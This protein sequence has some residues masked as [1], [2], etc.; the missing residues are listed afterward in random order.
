MYRLDLLISQTKVARPQSLICL[1][2]PPV[3]ITSATQPHQLHAATLAATQAAP[4][5]IVTAAALAT[6]AVASSTLASST[7]AASQACGAPLGDMCSP[8]SC[9]ALFGFAL[10]EPFMCVLVVIRASS[11]GDFGLFRVSS[12]GAT[13][14]RSMSVGRE[15]T[16]GPR[17]PPPPKITERISV[18]YSAALRAMQLSCN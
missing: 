4:V 11:A 5:L 10:F 6:A 3:T 16:D 8:G 18:R 12:F 9:P 15:P 14:G 1:R 13:V 7:L 17:V 2:F